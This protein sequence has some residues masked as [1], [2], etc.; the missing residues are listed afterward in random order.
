MASEADLHQ[1]TSK[2]GEPIA[3]HHLQILEFDS[4]LDFE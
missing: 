3:I 2:Q 1:K 4:S